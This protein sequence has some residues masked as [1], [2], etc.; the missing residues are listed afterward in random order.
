MQVHRFI[1]IE[2][3]GL[4]GTLRIIQSPSPAM[5]RAVPH[6]L[7]MP[8]APPNLA[9]STSRNALTDPQFLWAACATE[10][11]LGFKVE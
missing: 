7:R 1:V 8:R 6:Q 2:W 11:K 5:G 9:L 10:F 3:L 4:E